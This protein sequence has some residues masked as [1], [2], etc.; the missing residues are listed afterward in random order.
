MYTL[1]IKYNNK[2]VESSKAVPIM[3]SQHRKRDLVFSPLS[4][5]NKKVGQGRTK[6]ALAASVPHTTEYK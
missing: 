1:Y 6:R 4:L 5:Y 2:I 3:H